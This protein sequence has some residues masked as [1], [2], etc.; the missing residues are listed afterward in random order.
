MTTRSNPTRGFT[1]HHM[2]AIMLAFF[3]VIIAVNVTMATLANR[4]WTGLI[5]QNSYVASREFNA[6]AEKGREQ[7][8]LGW[9]GEL[10]LAEGRVGYSIHDRGGG[11]V[12]MAAASVTFRR[13][14]HEGEDRTVALSARN[15]AML[16]GEAKLGDGV[17]IVEVVADTGL[18]RPWR[19]VRRVVLRG[20][21][22]R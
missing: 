19:D 12:R 6:L 7:A 16:T 1:G 22:T 18:E 9:T 17:W 20:G 21:R 2:L 8:S 3:G 15:G 5:V 4:S 11:T 13:P 10:T 14:S